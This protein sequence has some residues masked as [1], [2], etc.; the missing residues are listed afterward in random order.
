MFGKLLKYEFKSTSRIMWLLY[1]GLIGVALLLGLVVRVGDV[2]D[3]ADVDYSYSG[4]FM[5]NE[6][7]SKLL[8]TVLTFL[9]IAYFLVLTAMMVITTVMIVLRFY[10]NLLGDEGYLM[11]T[12]P[13]STTKLI[14]SKLIISLLWMVF[15]GIATILSAFVFAVSS[16]FLGYLIKEGRLLEVI[17]EVLGMTNWGSVTLVLLSIL[18]ETVGSILMFYLSMAIGNMANKNKGIISVLAYLGIS[19]VLSIVLAVLMVNGGQYL[20]ENIYEAKEFFNTTSI[21]SI[22]MNGIVAVGCFVGTDYILKKK[23]NLA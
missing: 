5:E 20:M 6:A 19:T 3:L 8:S 10:R 11:H 15:A 22:I 13:V 14:V 16:G 9:G 2:F 21:V 4:I 17:K 12:L 23:L 1:V 7:M 18:V